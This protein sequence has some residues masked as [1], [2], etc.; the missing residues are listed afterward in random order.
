MAMKARAPIIGLF[1]AGGLFAL[2]AACTHQGCI[3]DFVSASRGFHCACHGATFSFVGDATRS[4]AFTPLVHYALCLMQNG[5]VGIDASG[6]T[7]P[8]T[9]RYNF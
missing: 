7:V 6:A 8:S 9:E 4:P 5:D 2:S 1:D 3:V